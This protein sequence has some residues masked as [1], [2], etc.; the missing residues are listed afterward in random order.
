MSR[1]PVTPM[2]EADLRHHLARQTE[3]RVV[4]FDFRRMLAD[5]AQRA[6]DAEFAAGA[7][8]LIL[9]TFDAATTLAAGR[10]MAYHGKTGQRFLIGSSGVEY[11]LAE[12]F[13]V[14]GRIPR[15]QPPGPRGPSDKLL[16]LC[17]SCSPVT[18]EQIDWAENHGFAL[19]A[20][21]TPHLIESNENDETRSVLIEAIGVALA[22]HN[23][24]VLHSARGPSDSR[25]APTRA[26]LD[27]LGLSGQD[28]SRVLGAFL[29]R[30]VRDVL[31]AGRVKRVLLAGG[32]SSSYAAE[33]MGVEALEVAGPLLPGA[34][35]CRIHASDRAIDGVE[36]VLKGGQAGGADAF[37]RV[38][39]GR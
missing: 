7:D 24:V 20:L 36:V 1:H 38:M 33:A 22:S 18:A 19:I 2:T 8:I 16:V 26:A 23:G 4:G 30:V 6:L 14:E 9:D 11:A 37:G 15:C 27:R 25:I 21:D 29:G 3:R 34:P 32:D 12:Q 39:E 17:G 28:S 35:L 10:L 5:D 31:A 13:A